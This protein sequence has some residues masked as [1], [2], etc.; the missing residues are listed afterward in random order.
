MSGLEAPAGGLCSFRS[1]VTAPSVLAL[2]TKDR[3]P[4]SNRASSADEKGTHAYSYWACLREVN[5]QKQIPLLVYD[6]TV[7]HNLT[8]ADLA[9]SIVLAKGF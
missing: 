6:V 4:A 2:S 9:L 5:F 7:S 3:L 1:T 8:S